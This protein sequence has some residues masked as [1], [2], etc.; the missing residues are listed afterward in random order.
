MAVPEP[1]FDRIMWGRGAIEAH[2]SKGPSS[3]NAKRR[4]LV[5]LMN[6]VVE[7]EGVGIITA[8]DGDTKEE[9]MVI[10][11]IFTTIKPSFTKLT[12]KVKKVLEMDYVV[13]QRAGVRS[14]ALERWVFAHTIDQPDAKFLHVFLNRNPK[15]KGTWI[16]SRVV[17][18]QTEHPVPP[19]PLGEGAETSEASIAFWREH[20]PVWVDTRTGDDGSPVMMWSKSEFKEWSDKNAPVAIK[21]PKVA[22]GKKKGGRA[23]GSGETKE[24]GAPPAP[25]SAAKPSGKPR[26]K[27][28]TTPDQ[29][30]TPPV[31]KSRG[32]AVKTS[33]VSSSEDETDADAW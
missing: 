21:E 1:V 33:P 32:K 16:V 26:S 19:L 20:V 24:E 14:A 9:V 29:Q 27:K 13:R 12:A 4:S 17:P 3:L 22:K 7:D 15:K 30:E 6:D 28:R 2:F 18:S 25:R 10:K 31:K 11:N 23:S 8:G 5:A